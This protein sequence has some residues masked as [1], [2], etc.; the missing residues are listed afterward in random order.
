M[1]GFTK[2][3]Y[4]GLEKTAHKLFAV[5]ALANLFIVCG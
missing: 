5:R 2:P 1:L 4:R 3:R